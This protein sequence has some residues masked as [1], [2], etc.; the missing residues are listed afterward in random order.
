LKRMKKSRPALRPAGKRS[1]SAS[2][3]LEARLLRVKLFL[4]DVDGVLTDG[5]VIMGDGKEYKT[6]HI[7]DGL[8]LRLLQRY[9]IKVGWVSNRPSEATR[10]RA[11]DLKVDYLFQGKGNK[12]EAVESI[13]KQAKLRWEDISYM[14]DDVVDLGALK[15]AGLAVAVSNGIAEAKAIAH[16]VTRAHGGNG[17]VREVVDLVLKASNVWT[18]MIAEFQA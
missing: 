5:T 12:V 7:Q 14:G 6:F 16:Y 18:K 10:E 9:G 3:S 17:A 1:R 8:G 2:L 13:L 15:R 4:C 11:E